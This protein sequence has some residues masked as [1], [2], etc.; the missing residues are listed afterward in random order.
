MAVPQQPFRSRRLKHFVLLV[1]LFSGAC[2]AHAGAHRVSAA[3][4]LAL[5]PAAQPLFF[6]APM[7]DKRKFNAIHK[8]RSR[9]EDVE[10]EAADLTLT[11]GAWVKPYGD[12]AFLWHRQLSRGLAVA[13]LGVS[14]AAEPL[15]GAAALSAAGDSGAKLLL[16]GRLDILEIKKRGAD[17]TGTNFTGTNYP[18]RLKARVKAVEVSSGR[19]VLDKD[20]E[21]KRRFFDPTRMG[22]PDHTTFPGFFLVGL[23]DAA[24]KLADWDELRALAGLPPV[25]PTPTATSTPLAVPPT[26]GPSP[27]VAPTPLPTVDASPYWV[28]PKTG[29]KVDPSWNFDPSDGTPR[30]DFILRQP[31]AKPTPE[32]LSAPR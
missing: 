8:T 11:A 17:F 19:T 6:L 30:K 14:A 22:A 16:S 26:P 15:D 7:A 1:S 27:T 10:I 28:N 18:L 32:R 20:F 13:G 12:V 5:S 24:A 25:T 31:A 9:Y 29:A 4:P 2:S 23:E 3:E 21:F